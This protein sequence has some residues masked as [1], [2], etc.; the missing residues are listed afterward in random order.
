MVKS[1]LPYLSKFATRVCLKY[2]VEVD[3]ETIFDSELVLRKE[4]FSGCMSTIE[5]VARSLKVLE[6]NNNGVVIEGKLISILKTMVKF[7]SSHVVKKNI[8]P[9]P[10]LKK[11]Y[12]KLQE[13]INRNIVS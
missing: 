7:Q 5:A 1:S 11:Q 2:D 13:D 3:G 12:K 9:R 8:K 4:P 6:E 10:M